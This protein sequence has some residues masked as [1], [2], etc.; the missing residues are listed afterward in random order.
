[1]ATQAFLD[2][3]NKPIRQSIILAEIEPREELAAWTLRSGTVYEHEFITF[4]QNDIVPGG[5]F[6]E[7]IS[8]EE[9]GVVLPRKTD[10][11]DVVN[12]PGSWLFTP[13]SQGDVFKVGDKLGD[14]LGAPSEVLI[15]HTSDS[16]APSTHT[17]IR[18]VFRIYFSTVA[19]IHNNVYYESR[20][21]GEQLPTITQEAEDLF[22]GLAK[23]VSSGSVSLNNADGLFDKL[24]A[25]W[26]WRNARVNLYVG[27][28][29][30]AHTQG[31]GLDY[32]QIGQ[33]LVEN[34]VPAL[35]SAILNIRDIHKI[36]LR[37][38]PPNF[39]SITTYPT[40]EDGAEGSPIPLIF[41]KFLSGAGAIQPTRIVG[42]G[43]SATNNTYVLADASLQSLFAIDTVYDASGTAF[44]STFIQ[45]S[46]VGCTFSVMQGH[47]L[48]N[49]D[50]FANV[51]GQPVQSQPWETSTDYL[52]NYG[53]LTAH[54]YTS[55]LG[56]TVG[57]I[58]AQS[59]LDVDGAEAAP[60]KAYL[61]SQDAA[62]VIIRSLERGVLGRTIRDNDGRLSMTIW[63]PGIDVSTARTISD[64]EVL[65]FEARLRI[66]SVYSKVN[67]QFNETPS[68]QTVKTTSADNFKTKLLYL[69]GR[70]VELTVSTLLETEGPSARLANRV[71]FMSQNPDTVV[72]IAETGIRLM[73]QQIGDRIFI[74]LSR[75][76]S[77][78]GSW[79]NEIF[80]IEK[81]IKT[82]APVPSV[83]VTLNNLRG[84]GGSVGIWT[85]DG[86]PNWVSASSSDKNTSGFWKDANDFAD[87]DDASSKGVS[88]WW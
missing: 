70:D 73:D 32:V 27:G 60:M 15:L 83:E 80:E 25:D 30:L 63:E 37:P 79:T 20:M 17:L 51:T 39:F 66:E 43:T 55:I 56:L 1:M 65:S 84:I 46:L 69:D 74:T 78:D 62:R 3:V 26:V 7:L 59:A 35:E 82:L 22:F 77:S 24:A 86:A 23:K 76:P 8:I 9:D 31:G 40:L 13:S 42:D 38:L 16:A 21:T 68:L 75:A 49:T 10:Q 71:A 12:T 34:F 58:N 41:G 47:G 19:A 18:A 29:G 52:K 50:V 11:L 85:S 87:P 64:P 4:V 28:P 88:V 44:G 72:R 14:K 33:H 67:V 81:I 48:T 54:L 61:N 36:T 5:L 53:E 2:F 45:K 6:R 57:E